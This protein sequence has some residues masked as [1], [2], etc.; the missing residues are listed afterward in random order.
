MITV[1][2]TP[3]A[4]ISS[5][6]VSGAASRSGTRA[7][8]AKGNSGSCFH[9]C[10]WGSRMRYSAA[11]GL[12]AAPARSVRREISGIDRFQLL[13]HVVP[14]S[15]IAGSRTLAG[16]IEIDDQPSLKAHRLQ[17]SMAGGK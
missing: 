9:T 17:H 8:S 6:S 4:F 12:K 2:L 11:S 1:R 15:L 5:M 10:T 16:D 14:T 13:Y 7:P 3:L